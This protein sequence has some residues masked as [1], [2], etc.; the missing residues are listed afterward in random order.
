MKTNWSIVHNDERISITEVNDKK[1]IEFKTKDFARIVFQSQTYECNP[2]DVFDFKLNV[3]RGNTKIKILVNWYNEEG[4]RRYRSY[5]EKEAKLSAPDEMKSFSIDVV[6]YAFSDAIMSLGDVEVSLSGK[7]QPKNVTMCAIKQLVPCYSN[8]HPDIILKTY[9]DKIDEICD[10]HNPDIIVMGE[11]THN[12]GCEEMFGERYQFIE[13]DGH[14]IKAFREKAKERK[15]FISG[16]FHIKDGYQKYNRALLIDRQGEIIAKYD[17]THLTI[18]EYESGITPGND[19]PVVETEIGRI[20]FMICWDLWFPGFTMNLFNKNCDIIVNPT[21]GTGGPQKNAVSYTSGAYLICSGS[22]GTTRIQ[23]KN[24]DSIDTV[25][26]KGYAVATVDLNEPEWLMQLSV[27]GGTNGE[28]RNVYMY[29]QRP[30]LYGS[31]AD[32]E[33]LK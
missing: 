24:G 8:T 32:V 18:A 3:E 10:K 21:R 14:I 31:L 11:H 2:R 15:I 1:Y 20:G 17:K 12:L 19:I 5:I 33:L 29:E 26:D 7:Y 6:V 23:D 4:T 22:E 13:E 16:S 30:D 28:G 27:G 25:G 9:L